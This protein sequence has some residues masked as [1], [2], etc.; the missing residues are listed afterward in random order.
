MVEDFIKKLLGFYDN[1]DQAFY[2]PTEWSHIGVKFEL[3]DDW[4]KSKSWLLV[5]GEENPYRQS[6]HKVFACDSGIRMETYSHET[7]EK[8]SDLIFKLVG[9]YWIS[10]ETVLEIPQ[11]N[12]Y[13]VTF[14]KFNGQE[15]HSRDAGYDLQTGNHL[16]GK[17]DIDGEFIFKRR[18]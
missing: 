10:D 2:S 5:N 4:V 14:I 17:R 12:I 18:C 16:W 3:D 1:Q 15:Y 7:N 9:D 6:Y 8:A 13:I 11:K